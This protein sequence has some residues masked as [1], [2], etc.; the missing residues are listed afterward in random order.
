MKTITDLVKE[1][2]KNW[3]FGQGAIILDGAT[4]SG[5]TSF[6][7]NTLAKYLQSRNER[8]LYLVSRKKL[9]DDLLRFVDNLD[10][11][12]TIYVTTYQSIQTR[13]IKH[14]PLQYNYKYIV[15]DECHYF[16]SDGWNRY[17][18][19]IFDFFKMKQNSAA[20]IFMSG[21]GENIF[22]WLKNKGFTTR[23]ENIYTIP[24]NYDYVEK[25]VF[26]YDDS[27]VE[28]I[29]NNLKDNEKCIYFSKTLDRAKKLFDK[30][31]DKANFICSRFCRY[32]KYNQDCIKTYSRDLITFEKPILITTTALDVG[33]SLIDR[34]IKYIITDLNN[35]DQLQ[36]CLGRKR[37]ID[38]TDT[39]I[40]YI[41][42]HSKKSL[43]GSIRT[44]KNA[45]LEDANKYYYDR[46]NFVKDHTRDIE[47]NP[48]FYYARPEKIDNTQEQNS[49]AGNLMFNYY[50][51]IYY[52]IQL[53]NL[54]KAEKIGFDE[55]VLEHLG[56]TIRKI[57][58][59]EEIEKQQ[60]QDE[61]LVYLD[62]IVGKKLF[63]DKQ[64]ELIKLIGL[65]DSRGRIQKSIK[66]F[67]AYFEANKM[68]Y[69]IKSKRVKVEG[70][71]HTVWIIGKIDYDNSSGIKNVE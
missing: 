69:I 25:V 35:I 43:N 48:C 62:S 56:S 39:C 33:V 24:Y 18:D 34:N 12:D 1:D 57:E 60:K 20:N 46:E 29:F 23:K 64:K 3:K 8:I 19:K 66:Q 54:K 22:N 52:L 36:Q 17:T 58:Y 21:T 59:L 15:Y 41:K 53:K 70:K 55:F 71:L 16:T 37:I 51:Y 13:L 11:D 31:K 44:I 5:K 67:N 49:K 2:Y 7:L 47:N 9:Q 10:L 28:D 68:D 65:K 42:N 50:T 63:K 27:T 32:K 38:T 6:I 40:F 61:L 14:K 45:V 30:Y 4:G 26:Y